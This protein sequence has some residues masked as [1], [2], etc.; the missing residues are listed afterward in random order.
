MHMRTPRLTLSL[1]VIALSLVVGTASAFAAKPKVTTDPATDITPVG[2]TLHGT[3]DPRGVA[4][5]AF[6]QYGTTKSYSQKTAVQSAGVA[7]GAVPLSAGVTK[8]KSSTVYHF[9]IVAQNAD[10]KVNGPDRTFTTAAPTTTPV[11]TPNPVPY[12]NPVYVSGNIVGSGAA[13]A[14][15]ALLG[16]PFP[17]TDPFAQVGNTVV[18]DASGNYL[19][20]LASALSTSQYEVQAKTNPAFT[21]SIETLQVASKISMR[22][23]SKVRKGHKVRFHGIVAPGQDGI[24]VEIQKRKRDGSFGVFARTN[25]RHRSDGQSSYSVRKKLRRRGIFIAVVQSAGGTVVPGVT[26]SAHSIRVVR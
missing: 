22:V 24:V 16:R 21:S 20:V 9:R 13:G 4:S 18:A 25:L 7:P 1:L 3:A 15:V 19:F 26:P 14:D 17:F 2:A 11:F 23:Q 12:G 8:L 10:G 5:S 6:F